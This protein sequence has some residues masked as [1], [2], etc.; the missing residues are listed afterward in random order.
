MVLEEI[1]HLEE[2]S[3]FDTA[4]EQRKQVVWTKRERAKELSH[5]ATL[6]TSN[7]KN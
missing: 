5:K 4:V 3:C 7:P 6:S 1:L 2:V